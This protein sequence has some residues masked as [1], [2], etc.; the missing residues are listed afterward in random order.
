MHYISTRSS[1]VQADFEKVVLSGL[2]DDGGLFVPTDLPL[3]DPLRDE[4][5]LLRP[6]DTVR[7]VPQKEGVC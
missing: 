4:P 5:V 2:A 6:G 7:F 3:F 1:T